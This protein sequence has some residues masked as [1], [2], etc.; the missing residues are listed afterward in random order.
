VLRLPD[1]YQAP[2]ALLNLVGQLIHVLR[3]RMLSSLAHTTVC[4]LAIKF[5][6][7][8]IVD[9]NCARSCRIGTRS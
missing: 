2:W 9:C 5:L 6:A 8:S 4:M 7:C 3:R 1:S